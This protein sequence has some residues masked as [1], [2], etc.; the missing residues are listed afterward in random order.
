MRNFR[1]AIAGGVHR[2]ATMRESSG[3]SRPVSS[4]A[5]RMAAFLAADLLVRLGVRMRC[6]PIRG[7]YAASGEHPGARE[8]AAAGRPLEQQ[9]LKTIG[10]V[11]KKHDGGG[12]I[13]I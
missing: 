7:V 8:R 6:G 10:A 9:H 12:D 13:D 2:A 3:T 5:S 11:A 4:R 1:G